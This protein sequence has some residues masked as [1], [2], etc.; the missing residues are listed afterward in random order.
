MV[1]ELSRLERSLGEVVAILDA[2]ASA[3]VVFVAIDEVGVDQADGG[4]ATAA[5]RA[6]RRARGADDARPDGGAS[7]QWRANRDPGLRQLLAAFPARA[8]RPQ[9]QDRATDA[10]CV[11][12]CAAFGSSASMAPSAGLSVR[13]PCAMHQS[14]TSRMR[15]RTLRAVGALPARSSAVTMPT[16]SS[17]A[18]AS[19]GR[20][21]IGAACARLLR[22]FASLRPPAFHPSAR[23]SMHASAACANVGIAEARLRSAIGSTPRWRL[24]TFS[25]AIS[26][27]SDRPTTGHGPRPKLRR[28]PSM[29]SR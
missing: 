17:L 4:P 13:W 5:R 29:V 15:W 8:G 25:K 3:G 20:S 24:R 26:R 10:R 28:L 21:A 16:T 9:P 6:R 23:I 19:T 22:Q 18:M 1:S 11:V 14:N 7:G 12:L 27:A 2:I